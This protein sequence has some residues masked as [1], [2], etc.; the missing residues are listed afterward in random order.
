MVPS[1]MIAIFCWGNHAICIC[2]HSATLYMNKIF[3]NS[4]IMYQ[5]VILLQA[6]KRDRNVH[7]KEI[8]NGSIMGTINYRE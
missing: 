6:K 7:K 4:C 1:H 2:M 5:K 3:N 8:K